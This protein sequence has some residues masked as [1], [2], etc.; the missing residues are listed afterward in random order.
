MIVTS[1]SEVWMSIRRKVDMSSCAPGRILGAMTQIRN[2]QDRY[3][4]VA[5]VLHWVIAIVLVALIVLGLYMVSLPD[6]GFDT[7]KIAL[8]LYHKELGIVALALAALRLRSR[9]GNALPHPVHE[10]PARPQPVAP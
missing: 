1:G 6:V 8:I 4:D 3:G 2:T 9:V 10:P 5:I 7:K